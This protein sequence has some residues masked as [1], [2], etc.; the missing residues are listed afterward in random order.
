MEYHW[1]DYPRALSIWQNRFTF[2][3]QE[4]DGYELKWTFQTIK[5]QIGEISSIIFS[6]RDQKKIQKELFFSLLGAKGF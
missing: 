3:S 1:I 6:F 2:P 5:C 4:N